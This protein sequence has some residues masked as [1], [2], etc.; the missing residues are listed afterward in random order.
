MEKWYVLIGFNHTH[1]LNRVNREREGGARE[2]WHRCGGRTEQMLG[3]M[4]IG[5]G[6]EALIGRFDVHGRTL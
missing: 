6:Q 2:M 5:T 3:C 1:R 4:R